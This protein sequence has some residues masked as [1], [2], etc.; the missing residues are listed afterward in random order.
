MQH[1]VSNYLTEEERELVS[2]NTLF[3]CFRV[4]VIIMCLLLAVPWVGL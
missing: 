3:S 2:K 1:L 4:A